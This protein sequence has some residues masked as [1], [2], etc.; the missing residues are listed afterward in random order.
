[1]YKYDYQSHNYYYTTHY[2]NC[3]IYLQF[4][5]T[6][7]LLFTLYVIILKV[8]YHFR[9]EFINMTNIFDTLNERGFI[10]QLTHPEEIKALLGGNPISFYLGIDC[11]IITIISYT[12]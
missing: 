6:I 9:K 1:M 3:Q 5:P 10:E 11:V 8:L 12:R 7:F 4:N 2:V